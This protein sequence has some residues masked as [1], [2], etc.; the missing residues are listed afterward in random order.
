M[1]RRGF[2]SLALAAFAAPVGIRAQ[3]ATSPRIGFLWTSGITPQYRD[4]FLR[5]LSELGYVDGRNIA[6]E[7]RAAGNV[8]ERLDPLARE[9]I[10]HDVKIVV[11]QG[12]AAAVAMDR[13]SSTIPV[14][15]AL[16]EP[17]AT[18]LIDS[19]GHPGRTVTGLT[20]LSS[21]LDAKR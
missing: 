4:A 9:L 15:M 21:Q 11:T 2:L 20:V 18:R 12:N 7:H 3:S 1:K 13:A 17:T 5:G 19:L 8:L 14:V 10:G 6:V 16:G